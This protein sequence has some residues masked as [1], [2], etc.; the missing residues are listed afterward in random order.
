MLR[1]Q[2]HPRAADWLQA[3]AIAAALF[4]LYAASAPRSVGLEDDAL[5]V[6]SAYFRGIEHPPGYPL[7]TL[8]GHL[9]SQL[10]FGSVAYRVH[11]A[12]ALFGALTGAAAYLCARSLIPGRLPALLAAV[13]LGVSPVFWS[14]SVIAEVYTLNTFFFLVLVYLGLRA[15]ASPRVLPVMALVFGLSLSNHYP[16]MLLAA[17]AFAVLLW[18]VRARLMDRMGF[19]VILVLVGLLPYV[20]MVRRSW[21]ALPISFN[22]EIETFAELWFFVSRAGYAGIDHPIS[23]GWLDRVKFFGFMGG[24]LFVQFAFAGALLAAAGFVAQWHLLG[25]RLAAFLTVS[26]VMPT[27]VLLSLLGFDYDTF[28]KHIFHV[29]PL[30]AYAV[31]ALW[32]GLGCHWLAQRYALRRAHQLAAAGV[33]ALVLFAWGARANLDSG[34]DWAARYALTVMKLLPKQAVVFAQGDA[35]LG[36]MSYFHMVENVRPD[37]T[38]YQAKGLILGNRLFHPLRTSDQA[39]NKIVQEFIEEQE[40]PVVFILDAYTGAARRDRW[41]YIEV[42]KS[43][44]DVEQTTIDIPDEAMRFFE[45]DIARASAGNAWIAYFQSEL[46]RRYAILLAQTFPQGRPADERARRHVELLSDDFYGALGLAEGLLLNRTLKS[47]APVLAYLDRAREL[48][49]ADAPKE[50]L[51]RYFSLRGAVRAN[52]GDRAGGIRDLETAFELYP[53]PDNAAIKPLET[54]YAETGERAALQALQDRVSHLK[55]IKR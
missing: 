18:P 6:L 19:L 5:F 13:A 39:A 33:L 44:D 4:A 48:L 28:R 25:R 22:G 16:L 41:L 11:L 38:L 40:D 10:P 27:F 52:L 37:I 23:A 50:H 51:A 36:P 3:L 46:R 47:A 2:F 26:F 45:Q 32:L 14:Q 24:Q 29:Y 1:L 20:W 34:H 43:S 54:L 17:P 53:V 35:D 7:F 9:F 21:M 15:E 12:S 49:P 30:P 8:I 31:M 42:D 55:R